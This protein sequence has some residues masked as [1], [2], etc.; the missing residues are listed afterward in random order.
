MLIYDKCF[1]RKLPKHWN[2][3]IMRTLI[4]AAGLLLVFLCCGTLYLQSPFSLYSQRKHFLESQGGVR[5][6]D[7]MSIRRALDK[8]YQDKGKYPI[9]PSYS[10]VKSCWGYQGPQWI[11]GLV[12]GYLKELPQDPRASEACDQQYFYISDGNGYKLIA[13]NAP[14]V[15][16]VISLFPDLFDYSRPYSSYAIWS[17]ETWRLQ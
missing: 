17:S 4:L 5:V 10:G 1:L 15:K 8:Y 7:L 14:D 3:T 13:H 12:P 11:P 6:N 16:K 9:Q 2:I